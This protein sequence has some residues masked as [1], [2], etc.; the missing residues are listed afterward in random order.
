MFNLSEIRRDVDKIMLYKTCAVHQQA[1]KEALV[2]AQVVDQNQ[3]IANIVVGVSFGVKSQTR[4]TWNAD[5]VDFIM[6]IVDRNRWAI[7]IF[8]QE[9]LSV[10]R[11]I[12][13]E[14]E[15]PNVYVCNK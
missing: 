3:E 1:L 6:R 5:S 7:G 12:E 8:K 14:T 2:V 9:L 15:F 11:V 10:I 13:G 4:T